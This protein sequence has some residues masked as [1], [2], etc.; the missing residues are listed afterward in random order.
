MYR[1]YGVVEH[2][3]GINSGH[4]TAYIRVSP[5]GQYVYFV[6]GIY[7]YTVGKYLNLFLEMDHKDFRI[8]GEVTTTKSLA[9]Y[10]SKLHVCE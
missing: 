9:D 1:L 8:F 10:F 6:I 5:Q 3:G 7:F 4:Y 2:G